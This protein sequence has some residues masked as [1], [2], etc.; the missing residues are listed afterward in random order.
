MASAACERW[1]RVGRRYCNLTE[2]PDNFMA[3]LQ[4]YNPHITELD[5]TSNKLT[6]LPE[7]LAELSYLRVVRVKYN[8]LLSIP[9][10][11]YSLKQC[12]TLDMAG[13]QIEDV[14]DDL[15]SMQQLRELDL[16]GN[17]IQQL[18]GARAPRCV[19]CVLARAV[20]RLFLE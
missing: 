16:S 15:V 18:T 4:K 12:T 2:L 11:V 13:N 7:E 6:G 8:Q 5:L 1:G 10:V 20:P 9:N 17:R 19:H 3:M 14:P